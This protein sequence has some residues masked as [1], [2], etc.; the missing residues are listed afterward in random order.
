MERHKL[1]NSKWVLNSFAYLYSCGSFPGCA[2][3]SE[4][5]LVVSLRSLWCAVHLL[6][7]FMGLNYEKF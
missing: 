4:H 2:S 6:V 5:P 7:E 1:L 3:V